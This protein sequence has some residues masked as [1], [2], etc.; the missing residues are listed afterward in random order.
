MQKYI[1]LPL[2][3]TL[4]AT[5]AACDTTASNPE[6]KVTQRDVYASLEDCV[7]DWGDTELCERQQKEAHEHAE[8]MAAAQSHSGGGGVAFVPMFFG[9]S[10]SGERTVTHNGRTIT[11][12]GYSSGRTANYVTNTATGNRVVSY[13][14]PGTMSTHATSAVSR[15]GF[16]GSGASASS[17][18]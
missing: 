4:A 11:P 6:E 9:P 3:V 7:A 13:S 17:G 16:G 5:V 2:V 14:K 1:Q 18:G 12:S 15:G 10:Y 8:K